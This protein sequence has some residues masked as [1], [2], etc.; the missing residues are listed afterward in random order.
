MS[1][2]ILLPGP[3]IE[4]KPSREIP[5]REFSGQESYEPGTVITKVSP[6][7]LFTYQD[8]VDNR[9]IINVM[10]YIDEGNPLLNRIEGY[11]HYHTVFE[12]NVI[13]IGNGN[14]RALFALESGKR[15]DIVLREAPTQHDKNPFR[16]TN[17]HLKYGNIF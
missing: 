5:Y 14:H 7:E 4:E 1:A 11:T 6:R 8:W 16:L 17:L 15:V 12:E 2:E 13:V 9:K 3:D 10:R